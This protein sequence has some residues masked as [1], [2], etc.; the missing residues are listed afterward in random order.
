MSNSFDTNFSRPLTVCRFQA[1]HD[2]TPIQLSCTWTDIVKLHEKHVHRPQKDGAMLGGYELRGKRCNE[3]AIARSIIQLD[4]DT[5][6]AKDK[7][8]GR[9]LT[10]TKTAPPIDAIAPLI[11]GYEWIS[12]S[13][14]CHEPKRG[15]I[16]YRIVILPDRDITQEE[17]RLI[18]DALNQQ[19]GGIIDQGALQWS[20]AFFLPSCPEESA[21]QAFFVHNKGAPLNVDEWVAKGKALDSKRSEQC[22][23]SK[24][25]K[26]T[27]DGLSRMLS[28]LSALD[29]DMA[30]NQ[31]IKVI[32][33]VA[34]HEWASGY[35][36]AKGWS[37]NGLK[38]DE[39]EFNK[40]WNSFSP[41]RNNGI[42][43]GTLYFLAKGAGWVEPQ[44][45][46]DQ[47]PGDIANGRLFASRNRGKL[48][49]VYPARKWAAWNGQRWLWCESG[50]ALEA[51][52][53]AVDH[54]LDRAVAALKA[55]PNDPEVKRQMQQ[56]AKSTDER[57]LNS[58]LNLAQSEV[59][60][61]IAHMG[62]LDSN[63]W[64]LNVENGVVDLKTGTLLDH[65][66]TML[67]TKMC[68]AMYLPGAPCPMWKKFL[69]DVFQGDQNLIDY[70]QR[71][72]GYSM[73]GLVSEEVLFFMFGFGA[74][75]KSVFI[76]TII[77]VLAD[78]AM[79]A[80]AS[81]LALR[82]NDDKGRASPEMAR[83]VGARFAVANETQSG[84]RLDEQLVKVLVSRE[85]IAARQLYGDYFEFMPT[86]AL[87]VR[88]NHKPIVTGDD[89]GIWRRIQLIPFARTFKPSE[90]D[91]QLEEKLSRERD[92][93]L[94]WMV[95]GCIKWQSEG[96]NPPAAVLKA[97]AQYRKESDVL[98]Q[99]LDEDC[100]IDQSYREEQKRVFAR[101]QNW[102]RDSGFRAMTKAQFTRKLYERGCAEGWTGKDR[103]YVGLKLKGITSL[104]QA[105]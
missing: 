65:H 6:G 58:M 100:D 61:G 27:P 25:V 82:R 85:R 79:T 66:Q 2:T 90:I 97:S 77:N 104:S 52:K 54:L 47:T 57:R 32:W 1:L 95:E 11:S 31:W 70:I 87:W 41:E 26:E 81:M 59:G 24:F 103:Q 62:E 92:G 8:T 22:K 16:K 19:L 55:N 46:S 36:I 50:E 15:V 7:N 64:L 18:L 21:E 67:H 20:Q 56:A 80:P 3:N 98:G 40:V 38:W 13:S 73:T 71:A 68:N 33:G 51:A 99:W 45:A 83:M 76:N 89:H 9:V 94:T 101:Y 23:V 29:P 4:V 12:V 5:E 74:N 42:T 75:G 39:S 84:D 35:E 69:S 53:K 93:I 43:G 102:C 72:L 105:A 37:M 34:A 88:G 28:A 10:V 86:H 14:H 30:R 17:Y 63:P 96:L 44:H 78:Y 49:Y 91:P 48:I 60:M